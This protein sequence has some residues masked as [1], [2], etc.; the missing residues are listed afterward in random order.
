MRVLRGVCVGLALCGVADGVGPAMAGAPPAATSSA[1]RGLAG[2]R[3]M[4]AQL[5]DAPPPVGKLRRGP[6]GRLQIIPAEPPKPP[7]EAARPPDQKRN[8]APT[9]SAQPTTPAVEAAPPPAAVNLPPMPAVPPMPVLTTA[10]P[11]PPRVVLPEPFAVELP[12]PGQATIRP[13]DSPLAELLASAFAGGLTVTHDLVAAAKL[14]MTKVTFTAWPGAP[15][16]GRAEFTTTVPLLVLPHGQKPVGVSTEERATGSNNTPKIVRDDSGAIHMAWLEAGSHGTRVMYQRGYTRGPEA[17]VQWDGPSVALNDGLQTPWNAYVGVTS[18]PGGAIVAWQGAEGVML[19]RIIAGAA[20]WQIAPPVATS[21][22][23]QG[24]ELGPIVLTHAGALFLLTPDCQ[25]AKSTDN[26][27]TWKSEPVPV[28]P[29]A[30]VKNIS[31]DMD[32]QGSI[33]AVFVSL[34][35]DRYWELRYVRRT[36]AGDWVDAHNVLGDVKAWR[37]AEDGH[38]L[39]DFPTIQVDP[40]QGI[41]VAWHGTA[42]TREYGKD[43]TFYRYR[44]AG[45]KQDWGGWREVQLLWPADRVEFFGSFAPSLALDPATDAVIAVSF[46]VNK[47]DGWETGAVQ[48]RGG[49]IVKDRLRLSRAGLPGAAP[50]SDAQTAIWFPSAAP[51]VHRPGS[52]T[53]WLDVIETMKLPP[54]A[55]MPHVIVYQATDVSR[56]LGGG[57][58]MATQVVAIADSPVLLLLLGSVSLVVLV[59]LVRLVRVLRTQ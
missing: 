6:D 49:K 8:A 17:R 40:K 46:F 24:R 39:A 42:N 34:V 16:A 33:H 31:A 44:P 51:T 52:G 3:V 22:A 41:H 18:V 12:G 1:T 48:L 54:E 47:R 50:E 21:V 4:L 45:G 36:P 43:E 5:P 58:D 25:L 13:E 2:E 10:A 28:P 29:G 55:K 57:G 23:S 20:G 9:P 11:P 37:A 32:G 27:T 59:L 14:G 38:V 26:G 53:A 35:S 7:V 30:R 19:R 56:W 15:G